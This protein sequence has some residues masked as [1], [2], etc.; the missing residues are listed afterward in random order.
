MQTK[1]R[2]R[3]LAEES[4]MKLV[5]DLGLSGMGIAVDTKAPEEERV[6]VYWYDDEGN[7]QSFDGATVDEAVIKAGHFLQG[8][9]VP[10]F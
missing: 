8:T 6:N 9:S 7:M 5:L 3:Y 1:A 4:I 2:D 10:P